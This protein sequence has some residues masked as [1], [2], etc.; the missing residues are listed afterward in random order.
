MCL[1]CIEAQSMFF[2]VCIL[3]DT[4]QHGEV[5][6]ILDLLLV[7]HAS[8]QNDLKFEVSL[9]IIMC[10]KINCKLGKWYV[11]EK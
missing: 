11:A 5:A 3:R 10:T 9:A 2:R 4:F 8:F 1:L 7:K 6:H